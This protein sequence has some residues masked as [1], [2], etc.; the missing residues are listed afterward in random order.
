MNK[1][2]ILIVYANGFTYTQEEIDKLEQ[3]FPSCVFSQAWDDNVTD[4][5]LE[6]ADIIVGYPHPESVKKAKS[7]RWLQLS[8][9]GVDK[10]AKRDLYVRSDAV[11]TNC[12]GNNGLSISDHVLGMM[13]LLSRN[14][15]FYR[16]QQT[17]GVWEKIVPSKDMFTSK[18]LIVGLGSVGS[19][20]A[21]KAKAL[22]V[23][24]LAIDQ[25]GSIKPE[26]VD[27]MHTLAEI[28]I[29]VPQVDFIVLCVPTTPVTTGLFNRT[30]LLSIP[31]D[32]YLI[33]VGRGALIDQDAL[34]ECLA[35]ESFAGAAIDVFNTEP[36]PLDSP[37]W[38]L[39][40]LFMTPHVA[41]KSPSAHVR[42][43]S[44][45]HDNLVRYLRGETLVNVIDFDR[46]Y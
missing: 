12:H 29:L 36:L 4:H 26:Y 44:T 42:H 43:F 33:N 9:I 23:T 20:L 17:S 6:V 32:S 5:Q 11:L 38:T 35:N 24:V 18:L 16:D 10:H 30:R 19:N 34:A 28:D 25:S 8:S 45:F 14:F 1:Y 2:R 13:L 27:E 7:L 37:L 31:H 41:G 22:G 21:R 46:M 40:K 39:K 15:H 3:E